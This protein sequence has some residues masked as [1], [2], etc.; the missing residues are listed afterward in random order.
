M[1]Q[2]STRKPSPVLVI[3]IVAMIM[4]AVTTAAIIGRRPDDPAPRSGVTAPAFKDGQS[5]TLDGT[6]LCLPHKNTSGPQTEECA[7]GFKDDNGIYYSLR[8]DANN[9]S[10]FM[11]QPMNSRVRII[12]TF[13]T[14][15]A[16]TIY[17]DVGTITITSIIKL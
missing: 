8:D 11:G 17:Q 4:A 3:V 6:I 1:K 9:Y 15:T 13:H 2:A 5:V 10:N 12:G 14:Q 7:Y 16:A